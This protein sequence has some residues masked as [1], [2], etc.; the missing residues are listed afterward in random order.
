MTIAIEPISLPDQLEPLIRESV[1]EGYR[2]VQRL[3][4]EYSS[5]ANRFDRPGERLAVARIGSEL[6]GICGLNEDPYLGD[7]AFVRLRHLYVSADWRRQ[8][9]ARRLVEFVLE[10][11]RWEGKTVVLRTDNPEADRFYRKL[12]FAAGNRFAHA[13]HYLLP[14]T[15]VQ[16]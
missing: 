13:T 14:D 15:R 4:D 12:G 2:F 5:G 7:P 10:E 8:G 3:A 1:R 11:A 6:I 9:V 16:K